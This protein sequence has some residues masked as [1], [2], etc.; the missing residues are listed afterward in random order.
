[1][2]VRQVG[3]VLI[4]INIVIVNRH[5]LEYQEDNHFA[6][7]ELK[8]DVSKGHQTQR[9]RMIVLNRDWINNVSLFCYS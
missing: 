7:D 9:F 6:K 4:L 1:M 8:N 2:S 5:S 3:R